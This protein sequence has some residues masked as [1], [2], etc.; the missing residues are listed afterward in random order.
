MPDS[1]LE[2]LQPSWFCDWC[3]LIHGNLSDVGARNLWVRKI[4]MFIV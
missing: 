3:Q 4:R 2:Y 1:G